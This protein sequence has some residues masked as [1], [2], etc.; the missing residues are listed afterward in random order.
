[1]VHVPSPD[2]QK[3]WSN[4]I[5]SLRSEYKDA[6]QQHPDAGGVMERVHVVLTNIARLARCTPVYVGE[7]PQCT[8]VMNAVE[9]SRTLHQLL[10][11][12][13]LYCGL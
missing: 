9:T 12:K 4:Q 10:R 3:L 1:M 13:P 11:R 6:I 8:E 5:A 7:S 2:F